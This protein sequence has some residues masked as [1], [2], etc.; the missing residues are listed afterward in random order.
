M[1]G[2]VPS[3]ERLYS[4]VGDVDGKDQQEG[5]SDESQSAG[6]FAKP[7]ETE[8]YRILTP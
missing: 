5:R 6:P 4:V 1:L 2:R 7:T 3:S 8:V